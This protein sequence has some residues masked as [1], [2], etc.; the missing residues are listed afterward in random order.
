MLRKTSTARLISDLASKNNTIKNSIT[1]FLE[2]GH[3]NPKE[4]ITILQ[5]VQSFKRFFVDYPY[6]KAN[7]KNNTSWSV[8][9]SG[10]LIALI[11]N[12]VETQK[13]N[14][15]KFSINYSQFVPI[16]SDPGMKQDIDNALDHY[17]NL[18]LKYKKAGFQNIALK[19]K[20]NRR[21]MTNPAETFKNIITKLD[22]DDFVFIDCSPKNISFES[23]KKY[24]ELLYTNTSAINL[25]NKGLKVAYLN[26]EF[27]IDGEAKETKVT[28]H[29]FGKELMENDQLYG[30]GNYVMDPPSDFAG[31][32]QYP[33]AITYY[34]YQNGDF[35]RFDSGDSF[36]P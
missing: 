23:F 26:P 5:T 35:T 12:L 33:F 28:K 10:D 20:L 24:K 2:L 36:K 6:S 17:E 9:P 27:Y 19:L 7:L 18:L 32:S 30:Y 25:I 13:N 21:G 22:E 14:G 34:N 3:I 8:K 16:I 29:N 31:R 11:D 4:D 1:P 15:R